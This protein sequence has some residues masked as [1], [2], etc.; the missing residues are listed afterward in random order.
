LQWGFTGLML[1]FFSRVRFHCTPS[2]TISIPLADGSHYA[3]CVYSNGDDVLQQF[4]I[5]GAYDPD[6]AEAHLWLCCGVLAVLCLFY[7]LLAL[8][9]LYRLSWQVKDATK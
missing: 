3:L 5:P 9:M 1:T 7:R 2:Q 4:N 8:F 6:A